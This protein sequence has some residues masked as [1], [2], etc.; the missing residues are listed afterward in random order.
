MP[1]MKGAS[2]FAFMAFKLLKSAF[3]DIGEGRLSDL[4]NTSFF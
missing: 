3:K 1:L 4:R 2:G